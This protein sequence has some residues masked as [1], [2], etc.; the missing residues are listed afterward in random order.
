M[1]RSWSCP[2]GIRT[3]MPPGEYYQGATQTTVYLKSEFEEAYN[4]F[5]KE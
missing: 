1:K 5:T 2:K 4:Q 3:F